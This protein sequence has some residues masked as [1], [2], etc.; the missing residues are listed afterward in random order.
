[1]FDHASEFLSM[2]ATTTIITGTTVVVRR[3]DRIKK[4]DEC[5]RRVLQTS[6]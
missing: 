3:V 1:M 5:V 4:V 6:Y 2:L